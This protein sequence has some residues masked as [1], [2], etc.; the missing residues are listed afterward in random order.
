MH[1]IK[2]ISIYIHATYIM[3]LWK[4]NFISG[5]F[6]VDNK[7]VFE[8]GGKNKTDYQVTGIKN[9]FIAAD[10]IEIGV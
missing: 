8:I 4:N 2:C 10:D 5:D 9:A 6:T 1:F 7:W 3:Q